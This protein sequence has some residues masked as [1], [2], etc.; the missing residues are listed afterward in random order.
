MDWATTTDSNGRTGPEPEGLTSQSR[1]IQGSLDVTNYTPTVT[2]LTHHM[3]G[4]H[5]SS[6]DPI[7]AYNLSNSSSKLPLDNHLPYLQEPQSSTHP[8]S[9]GSMDD[10]NSVHFFARVSRTA[11]ANS[12]LQA[13]GWAKASSGVVKVRGFPTSLCCIGCCSSTLLSHV[14][15]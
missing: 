5:P 14:C 9:T 12:I 2:P 1:Q 7:H 6:P 11:L 8:L 13:Y 10:V 15:V 4:P 3:D